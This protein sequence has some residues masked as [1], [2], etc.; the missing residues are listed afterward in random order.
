[1]ERY[2]ARLVVK[3]YSQQEGLDYTETFS[4]V[5]KMVTVRAF[6]ALAVASDWFI[7]QMDV[8]NPFFKVICWKKST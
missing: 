6:I 1:M 8:H 5:S 4:P 2:K 3:G 7:F